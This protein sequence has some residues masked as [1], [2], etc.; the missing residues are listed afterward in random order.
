MEN[1]TTIE[2]LEKVAKLISPYAYIAGGFYKDIY[3]KK[4]PKDIDIFMV[5]QKNY[6]KVVKIIQD[7]E[8][9]KP[10]KTKV[11]TS[12]GRFEVIRPLTVFKRRLWGEPE[13]VTSSF[14]MSIA[15]VYIDAT[16]LVRVN[17]NIDE[18]VFFKEFEAFIYEGDE[19]RT[20]A[21][22]ERYE[23]YGYACQSRIQKE[24]TMYEHF[25]RDSVFRSKSNN[26]SS[27][28]MCTSGMY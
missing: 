20:E 13:V 11:A 27:G 19:E 4:E 16:G 5:A 25:V 23:E 6:K 8:K 28:T 10:V 14:D 22:I 24:I 12:I 17:E 9:A 18:E 1:K 3:N 7:Y 26:R 2:E 21:R 15:M